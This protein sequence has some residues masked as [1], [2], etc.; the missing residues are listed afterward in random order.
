MLD[1]YN[2]LGTQEEIAIKYGVTQTYISSIKTG[3]KKLS[4]GSSLLKKSQRFHF[5]KL[6]WTDID[7]IHE[8][9]NQGYSFDRLHII[10]KIDASIVKKII[11]GELWDRQTKIIRPKKIINQN[12]VIP[13]RQKEYYKLYKSGLTHS[14]IAKK[15]DVARTTITS[16]LNKYLKSLDEDEK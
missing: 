16:N 6:N 7:K 13:D 3:K 15:F 4:D 5:D 8:L 1:I 9:Y 14:Q 2:D 11:K 12:K 10:Y